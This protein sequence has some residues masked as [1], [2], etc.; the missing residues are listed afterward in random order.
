VVPST[1]VNH[2]RVSTFNVPV[3][4][5]GAK[6]NPGDIISADEDGVVAVPRA[7]AA[8]VLKKAQALDDSEHSMYPFIEK[9]KSIKEAVDKF[10][11]I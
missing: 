11:R 9:Y 10:G 6:V 4:C 2:Y 5:A 7:Q 3:V 1:T 8:E